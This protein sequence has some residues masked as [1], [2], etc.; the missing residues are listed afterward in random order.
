MEHYSQLSRAQLS[1]DYLHTNST[2]HEFL[3]GAVA[4]LID[5]SRDAGATE[6]D[7]YTSKRQVNVYQF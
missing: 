7:I 2:T 4:E 6:L 3:F 5:N 1:F